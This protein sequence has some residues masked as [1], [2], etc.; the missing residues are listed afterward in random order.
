[1]YYAFILGLFPS[2]FCDLPNCYERDFYFRFVDSQGKEV[3]SDTSIFRIT[4]I[5]G[6]RIQYRRVNYC[7][8]L[9]AYETDFTSRHVNPPRKVDSVY[10]WKESTN[11]TELIDKVFSMTVYGGETKC[12]DNTSYLDSVYF[13]N[14]KVLPDTI[15]Y[16]NIYNI[17]V[18]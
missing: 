6:N 5:N 13:E 8:N 16:G 14:L 9:Y 2:C 1:M 7:G 3:L 11:S 15:C 4:D 18:N 10:F 17:L 12:C